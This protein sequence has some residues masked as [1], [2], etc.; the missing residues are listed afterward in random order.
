MRALVDAGGVVDKDS[1]L[2]ALFES[3]DAFRHVVVGHAG[4]VAELGDE[5]RGYAR[6]RDRERLG[7]I[8]DRL[9]HVAGQ[10]GASLETLQRLTEQAQQ[11]A[12]MDQ[13][14]LEA[15][16][17]ADEPEVPSVLELLFCGACEGPIRPGE[18]YHPVLRPDGTTSNVHARCLDSG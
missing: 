13:E 18:R 15:P 17:G 3:W 6:G 4:T 12:R 2:D 8:A 7:A 5:L 14:Q 11:T 9:E 16:P 1:R 10:L